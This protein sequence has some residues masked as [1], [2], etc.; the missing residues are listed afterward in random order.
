MLIM[1]VAEEN[2]F[3]GE[4]LFQ[5]EFISAVLANLG[6]M[7]EAKQDF[8]RG[9]FWTTNVFRHE[10]LPWL[11]DF[12]M[13]SQDAEEPGPALINDLLPDRKCILL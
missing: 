2:P 1:A 5:N 4:G 9:A 3:W 8:S 12:R 13:T 11:V 10:S 7:F 6:I